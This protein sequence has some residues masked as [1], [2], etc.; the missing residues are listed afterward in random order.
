MRDPYAVLGVKRTAGP[1]EIKAAWRN[2][3]KTL[4]PDRNQGD[5]EAGTRFAEVGQA[6]QLLKDPLA[7]QRFD[8][9]RRAAEEAIRRGNKTSSA[10]TE[11]RPKAK[12]AKAKPEASGQTSGWQ[13][14]EAMFGFFKKPGAK[15]TEKAPDLY[16][17]ILVTIEDLLRDEQLLTTLP[18]GR[19]IK[20][21]LPIGAI[22]GD[23]IRVAGHGFKLPEMER[24]DVVLTLRIAPHKLFRVKG[25]DLYVDLAVDVENAIL[26]CETIADT[27]SGPVKVTVPEWTGSDQK[28]KIEGQ[29]LPLKV[30]GR[31]NLYAEVRVMLWDHPDDKVKDLMRSLREGL[32]L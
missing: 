17:D 21:N 16:A 1:E 4:H 2:L 14:A 15:K 22:E 11:A 32:F 29:G 6:Y 24:G 26:G 13:T 7:R 19:T 3:A 10:R 23:K 31:G 5:P 27:P 25:H 20:V 30:G 18:D 12:S 28:I 8:K 9:E